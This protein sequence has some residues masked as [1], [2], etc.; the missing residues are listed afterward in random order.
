MAFS[1]CV[2]VLE[3]CQGV[4]MINNP[5][6]MGKKRDTRTWACDFTEILDQNALQQARSAE[7]IV[8]ILL[9]KV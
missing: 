1:V 8:D 6:N 2:C 9:K 7:L 3:K 4:R 5:I